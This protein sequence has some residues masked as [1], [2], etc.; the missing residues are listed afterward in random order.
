M[1][2]YK[3]IAL[4]NYG[5]DVSFNTNR[6]INFKIAALG[7][8]L[9]AVLN[10][11]NYTMSEFL[12]AIK[13]ALQLADP[14]NTYTVV[15]NRTADAFRGNRVTISSSGSYFSLL[16]GTGVNASNSPAA[17]LGFDLIDYTGFTSYAGYQSAG[18]ILV[19]GLPTYDYL[20]PENYTEK[21]GVKNISSSGIKET[22]VFAD[23]R[24]IN[25]EWK[26]ISNF[27]GSGELTAWQNFIDYATKQLSFEMTPSIYEDSE[28]YY[29]VTLEKT[30][31]DSNG[32]KHQF[33][34]MMGDG[35]YRFYT[36]GPLTFRVKPS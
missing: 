11:G 7:T 36:T 34:Q 31:Q 33:K 23:M 17:L 3:D 9:T 26:Y 12:L 32:M 13:A 10:P 6:Y 21:D 8:P 16:F 15:V 18:K 1:S 14:T 28:K 30:P 25:G 24:F 2:G 22:L 4:F 35:L 19:A 27:D 20:S 5:F 29:Q